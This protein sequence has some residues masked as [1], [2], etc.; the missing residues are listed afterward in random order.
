MKIVPKT[1]YHFT[2]NQNIIKR[3]IFHSD[4]ERRAYMSQLGF[5][6]ILP[7]ENAHATGLVQ[8]TGG[9]YVIAG[10]VF[11][12]D[13]KSSATA[14]RIDPD[15]LIAWEKTYSSAFSV[16]FKAITQIG[17]GNFVA[18]G[19]FFYSEYSGDEY[20]WVVKLD[21]D[22]N[23]I[24]EKTFGSKEQ[25][26]DGL[27]VI[28]T[29]DGGFAVI[30]LVLEKGTNIVGTRVMKFDKDGNL[31][32][33]NQFDGG[34]AYSIYQTRNGGYVLSGAHNIEDSF[35]SNVYVLRLDGEGN[36]VWDKI[37]SDYEIYVLIDSGIVETV[38][39]GFA[40]VAK[41]VI[42]KTD[43]CGNIT[44]AYQG[45]NLNLGTIAQL[46][47]GTYAVGGG[48]IVNYFDHAYVAVLGPQGKEILWDNIEIFYPGV[49]TKVIVNSEQLVTVTGYGPAGVNQSQMFLA[50]YYPAK[51]I[52]P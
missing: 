46:P 36:K 22:G 8:T 14:I 2:R 52:A 41:S 23:I 25:Q 17:D 35:N 16:F 4:G 26:S 40:L 3:N 24:W 1:T 49:L 51:T 48:L 44:W 9:D 19:S 5:T 42:M 38:D 7:Q 39:G 18:T 21:T 32:W 30:G 27:D 31:Q 50:I 29:W 13:N 6:E 11:G 34:V 43:A 45:D 12:Q 28:A 10:R 33:D 15:G 37:Y 47:D 20:I